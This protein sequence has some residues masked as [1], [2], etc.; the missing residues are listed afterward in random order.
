MSKFPE[1]LYFVSDKKYNEDK[2]KKVK[3]TPYEPEYGGVLVSSKPRK[4]GL[5][6]SPMGEGGLTFYESFR[7]KTPYKHR[8]EV[9]LKKKS[10]ILII[11]N[12]DDM[13]ILFDGKKY[14]DYESLKHTYDV[15]YLT[16]NGV[17]ETRYPTKGYSLSRDLHLHSWD[18]P[19]VLVLNKQCIKKVTRI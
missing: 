11:D 19:T 3:N 1:K 2:I 7:G 4:G 6:L 15:I 8:Y 14:V 13:L 16:S 12:A 5:W 17:E 9:K 18:I 10:R